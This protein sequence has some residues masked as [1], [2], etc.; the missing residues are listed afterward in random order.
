M[1]EL[2]RRLIRE[3]RAKRERRLKPSKRS[4][5]ISAKSTA[6]SFHCR[7]RV[8]YRPLSFSGAEAGMTV[9][10][11]WLADTNVVSE[12]MRPRPEPRVAAFL[13][14]IA[15]EG[16]ASLPSPSGRFST[17]SGGSIR[18]GAGVNL[19]NGSRTSS[20][21]CSRTGSS[22][23]LWRMRRPAPG[24]W[25]TGAAAASR[26]DHVPDAFLAAAA[27][28]RGLTVVTRNPGGVPEHRRRNGGS[29]DRAPFLSFAP[30]AGSMYPA[31]APTRIS[32][33]HK[34]PP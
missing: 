24:S 9:P 11:A 34:A 19:P 5:G 29:L 33:P 4:R 26:D 10:L 17:A 30:D 20:T 18:G 15:D 32:D 3:K 22:R 14:S 7:D 23:G 8:S 13:D 1:E 16:L 31:V 28:V 25:R 2:V 6:S 27:A 21:I 12:M